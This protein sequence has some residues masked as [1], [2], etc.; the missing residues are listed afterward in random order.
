MIFEMRRY[1][2]N[3]YFLRKLNLQRTL[4]HVLFV[5]EFC[6]AAAPHRPFECRLSTEVTY[7]L[8]RQFRRLA[9]PLTP[10]RTPNSGLPGP[11]HSTTAVTLIPNALCLRANFCC[12]LY[13]LSTPCIDPIH[14]LSWDQILSI[15]FVWSPCLFLNSSLWMTTEWS[16]P[17]SFKFL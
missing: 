7:N 16:Y 13:F 17:A 14:V 9:Q 10:S 8:I 5:R 12:R 2:L 11:A 6:L 15:E 1:Y 4:W 3:S